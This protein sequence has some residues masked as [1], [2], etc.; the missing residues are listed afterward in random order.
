MAGLSGFTNYQ[1]LNERNFAVRIEVII[2]V[3]KQG[4][5]GLFH[6]ALLQCLYFSEVIYGSVL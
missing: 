3:I 1:K 6:A 5:P 4:H 2:V